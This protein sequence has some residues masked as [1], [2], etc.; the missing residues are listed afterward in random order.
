MLFACKD[1]STSAKEN[2]STTSNTQNNSENIQRNYIPEFQKIEDVITNHNYIRKY[3]LDASENYFKLTDDNIRIVIPIPDEKM[4]ILDVFN[5]TDSSKQKKINAIVVHL[6]NGSTEETDNTI[7]HTLTSDLK[8]SKI[9]GLSKE[10][11]KDGKLKVYII[12]EDVL[13]EGER[14]M[15]MKCA[16][17]E[18]DYSEK[19]CDLDTGELNDEG[20]RPR[21]QEGDIITGG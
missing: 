1:K 20:I 3:K 6:S 17:Q 9:K 16:S 12:N 7:T 21:E 19:F 13:D 10:H 4:K 8:I 15:F 11:L 14:K 2:N 5:V 18:T